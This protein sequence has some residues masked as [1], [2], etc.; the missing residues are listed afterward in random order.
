MVLDELASAANDPD[1]FIQM[2]MG[3]TTGREALKKGRDAEKIVKAAK[4]FNYDALM[5]AVD[6]VREKGLL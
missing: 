3:D 4:K 6:V 5:T 2:V 1:D